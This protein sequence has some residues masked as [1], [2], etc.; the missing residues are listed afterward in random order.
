MLNGQGKL[1]QGGSD[2]LA[3]FMEIGKE[4]SIVKT[5]PTNVNEHARK[6]SCSEDGNATAPLGLSHLLLHWTHPPCG[7]KE[8]RIRH[9]AWSKLPG[10]EDKPHSSPVLSAG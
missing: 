3:V 8:D 6:S 9:A 5:K 1:E 7:A 2:P 10:W 4:K